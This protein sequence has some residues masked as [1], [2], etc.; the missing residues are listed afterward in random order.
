MSK[1][2][3]TSENSEQLEALAFGLGLRISQA[4]QV[5]GYWVMGRTYF[6]VPERQSPNSD[7]DFEI[8]ALFR[9]RAMRAVRITSELRK[10]LIDSGA[11]E[12]ERSSVGIL[13]DACQTISD[14]RAPVEEWTYDYT[15]HG[16]LVI[17]PGQAK[18]EAGQLLD[19]VEEAA[20]SSIRQVGRHRDCPLLEAWLQLGL[21]VSDCF[22]ER[23]TEA[24]PEEWPG[25]EPLEFS[26]RERFSPEIKNLEI[27][28]NLA[29]K[30]SVQG[31]EIAPSSWNP[32]DPVQKLIIDEQTIPA[33]FPGWFPPELLFRTKYSGRPR[34]CFGRDQLFLQWA[35]NLPP[36]DSKKLKKRLMERWNNLPDSER[37]KICPDFPGVLKDTEPVK[38]GLRKAKT[39]REL[40]SL[41]QFGL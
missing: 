27:V 17:W 21:V 11:T 39:E 7:F 25:L 10:N 36:R 1:T 8:L 22:D 20:I 30:L 4:K 37:R 28:R 19:K 23:D 31:E 5:A 16:G 34:A 41:K 2:E 15:V 38:A 12:L 33:I 40:R 18:S 3:S 13:L 24:P 26:S 14:W 6:D 9:A 29:D 32:Y 35:E